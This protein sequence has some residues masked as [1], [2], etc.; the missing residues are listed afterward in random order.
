MELP[1]LKDGDYPLT[2][3]GEL[4]DSPYS[5]ICTHC[6]H[7]TEGFWTEKYHHIEVCHAFPKG[8]PFEIWEGRNDHAKP[9]PGDQGIRFERRE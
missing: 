2:L 9:Y 8:I 7:L 5:E 3:D 1:P 4:Y 6:K